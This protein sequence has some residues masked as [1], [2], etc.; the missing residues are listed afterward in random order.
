MKP[1]LKDQVRIQKARQADI[2]STKK[3][4]QEMTKLSHKNANKEKLQKVAT[5]MKSCGVDAQADPLLD[6]DAY[7]YDYDDARMFKTHFPELAPAD[8]DTET[9]GGVVIRKLFRQ[10]RMAAYKRGIT[11]PHHTE[12]KKLRDEF[13]SEKGMQAMKMLVCSSLGDPLFF[14]FLLLLF[15]VSFYLF[16]LLW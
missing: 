14:C 2:K 5:P 6:T 8:M 16:R 4:E 1:T 15:I 10:M 11:R 3:T 12:F 13:E 7:A 9:I